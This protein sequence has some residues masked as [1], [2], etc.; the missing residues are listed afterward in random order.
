[1]DSRQV[2]ELLYKGKNGDKMKKLIATLITLFFIMG[3]AASFADTVKKEEEF[4]K[5][6]C[7]VSPSGIKARYYKYNEGRSR[8]FIEKDEIVKARLDNVRPMAWHPRMDILVVMEDAANDDNRC[9]ILNIG[10]KEFSKNDKDRKEYVMGNRYVNR[11]R[12]SKDGSKVILSS[13]F[14]DYEEEFDI[15]KYTSMTK[16]DEKDEKEEKKDKEENKGSEDNR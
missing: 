3:I 7:L 13:T 10:E 5:H 14:M 1:M 15:S 12:W 11:V 6:T 4:Q 8:L 16:S 9:Y 2:T